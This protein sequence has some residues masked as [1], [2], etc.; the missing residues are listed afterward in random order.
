MAPHQ[1][2]LTFDRARGDDL[3]TQCGL[4]VTSSLLCLTVLL[5]LSPADHTWSRGNPAGR[6]ATGVPQR[7]SRLPGKNA[8]PVRVLLG[9]VKSMG[10]TTHNA[11]T[12]H[13]YQ[14]YKSIAG[15]TGAL[16]VWWSHRTHNIGGA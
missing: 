16:M 1:G 9:I 5:A 7:V 11:T 6:S 2:N 13:Y 15:V 4:V 8:T 3:I 12:C 14:S 10:L